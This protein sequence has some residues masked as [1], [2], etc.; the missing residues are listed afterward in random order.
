MPKKPTYEE[1]EQ[2]VKKLE[3]EAIGCKQVE[4]AL[5]KSEE[6]YKILTTSSLT[7]IFIHQ[8]GRF[9]FVNDRFAKLH[10][11]TTEE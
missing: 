4:E 9:V 7:G 1:L 5:R 10:G 8:D 2:R 3:K 6:K 11:Y